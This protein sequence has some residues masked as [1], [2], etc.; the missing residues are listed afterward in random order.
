[1]LYRFIL[2]S[3]AGFIRI[4]DFGARE[5]SNFDDFVISETK[6]DLMFTESVPGLANRSGRREMT[7]IPY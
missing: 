6:N 3:G 5:G 7:Q 4:M 1:M 2:D